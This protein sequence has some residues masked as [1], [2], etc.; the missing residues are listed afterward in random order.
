MVQQHIIELI[1][2]A[3]YRHRE[4]AL[5]ALETQFQEGEPDSPDAKGYAAL[6]AA[7]SRRD[8]ELRLRVDALSKPACPLHAAV[9]ALFDTSPAVRRVALRGVSR[10]LQTATTSRGIDAVSAKLLSLLAVESEEE[11]LVE[12]VRVLTALVR[13]TD[14]PLDTPR[15][16]DALACAEG[17]E[18]GIGQVLRPSESHAVIADM[19]EHVAWKVRSAVAELVVAIMSRLVAALPEESDDQA[20]RKR[21]TGGELAVS[22]RLYATCFEVAELLVQ[23]AHAFVRRDA[24]MGLA[25]MQREHRLCPSKDVVRLTESTVNSVLKMMQDSWQGASLG[26]A[27]ALEKPLAVFESFP[28]ATLRGYAK[29]ETFLVRRLHMARDELLQ[30]REGGK[31]LSTELDSALCAVVQRNRSF[32]KVLD[33][34]RPLS[35]KLCL[36]RATCLSSKAS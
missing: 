33:L 2:S 10:A 31:E 29:A 32:A 11:L 36:R 14:V 27:E 16:A 7:V 24:V 17:A 4:R 20:K 15:L 25:A 18:H 34:A 3:D 9:R 6:L 26:G 23:D 5:R 13:S 22:T 35:Q 30:G 19:A 1:S 12:S 28:C 21:G 8:P